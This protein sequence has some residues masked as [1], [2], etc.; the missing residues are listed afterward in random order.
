MVAAEVLNGVGHSQHVCLQTAEGLTALSAELWR[1]EQ[2]TVLYT[3]KEVAEETCQNQVKRYLAQEA[4]KT[5]LV[6][7]GDFGWAQ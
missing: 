7:C 3:A 6:L 5:H 1:R 4:M 2:H